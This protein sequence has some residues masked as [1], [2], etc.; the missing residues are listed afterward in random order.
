MKIWIFNLLVAGAL[1][2]LFLGESEQA[3]VKNDLEWAKDKVEMTKLNNSLGD[4]EKVDLLRSSRETE[5]ES[6]SL[7]ASMT[8]PKTTSTANL[9]VTEP[10]M[11]E[12]ESE[13][14]TKQFSKPRDP[15]M[16]PKSGSNSL[17]TPRNSE[18]TVYTEAL[19]APRLSEIAETSSGGTEIVRSEALQT[20]GVDQR[21]NAE[22]N[23]LLLDDPKIA[24]RRAIVLDVE[25][26]ETLVDEKTDGSLMEASN[27]RD[28]LNSLA[29]DMELL[30]VDSI[31]R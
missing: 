11:F 21:K 23:S 9:N 17:Q 18:T 26:S 31:A 24:R 25:G 8:E 20:S 5:A 14:V 30:F 7:D 2:Y 16:P 13:L 3:R 6:E 12:S 28:A 27:R 29:E 10:R 15:S 22:Q 4:D 1:A 19:A